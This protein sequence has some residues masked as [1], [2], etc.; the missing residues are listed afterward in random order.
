[1]KCRF[2][3]EYAN[4]KKKNMYD[5]EEKEERINRIDHIVKQGRRGYITFDEVMK[6]I[7]EV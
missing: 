7:A 4:F 3:D 2:I 6:E 1:M 5:D